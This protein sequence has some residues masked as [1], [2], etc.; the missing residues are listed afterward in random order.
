[1]WRDAGLIDFE[2][3]EYFMKRLYLIRHAKSSWEHPELPDIERP[4][5]ERGEQDT[6]E[7]AQWLKEEGVSPDIIISSSAKRA[8]TTAMM[9]AEE[10]GF[11]TDQVITD[12]RIY[13]ANVEDL[14]EVIKGLDDSA[15]SVMFFGHVP[16][17]N[18]LANYLCNDHLI[19]IPTCGIYC[20]DFATDSWKD[21]LDAENKFIFFEYPKHHDEV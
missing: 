16:S 7:M 19:N 5:N 18:M 12:Q 2:H 8:L 21:F 20:I 14:F 13:D 11:P 17:L 6:L 1:M 10:L 4:L 3:D 9:M 15:Q